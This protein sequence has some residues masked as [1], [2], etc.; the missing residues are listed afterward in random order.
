MIEVSAISHRHQR[1]RFLANQR[2]QGFPTDFRE[3]KTQYIQLQ[4]S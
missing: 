1:F 4:T 2:Y 3:K